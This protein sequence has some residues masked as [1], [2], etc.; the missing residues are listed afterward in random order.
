MEKEKSAVKGL[1]ETTELSEFFKE[2][3]FETKKVVYVP[4]P[5]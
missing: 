1:V 3:Y 2:E 5:V 4:I